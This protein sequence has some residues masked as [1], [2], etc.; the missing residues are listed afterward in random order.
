[1]TF[2]PV[3]LADAAAHQRPALAADAGKEATMDTTDIIL[4]AIAAALWFGLLVYLV[5]SDPGRRPTTPPGGLKESNPP[6]SQRK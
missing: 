3:D 6:R 5:R 4:I 1:V 2:W